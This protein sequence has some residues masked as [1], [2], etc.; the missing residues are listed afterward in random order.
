MSVQKSIL[1]VASVSGSVATIRCG[2]YEVVLNSVRL[3]GTDV[4]AYLKQICGQL[5]EGEF[6]VKLTFVGIRRTAFPGK[7]KQQPLSIYEISYTW[8][9][10]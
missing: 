9:E 6:G 2:K 10:K 3:V 1:C 8:S 5:L 7:G 4:S